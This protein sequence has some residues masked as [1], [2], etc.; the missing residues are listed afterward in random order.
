MGSWAVNWSPE[1][2][3]S[4]SSDCRAAGEDGYGGGVGWCLAVVALGPERKQDLD[5]V[6]GGEFGQA[7]RV[8]R[9]GIGQPQVGRGLPGRGDELVEPPR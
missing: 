9:D 6:R 2:R 1:V 7:G 4:W 5:A 8:G 3:A